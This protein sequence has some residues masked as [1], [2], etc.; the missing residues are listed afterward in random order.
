MVNTYACFEN[1]TSVHGLAQQF[2]DSSASP[3]VR[4]AK[5]GEVYPQNILKLALIID[6]LSN[7]FCQLPDLI[8]HYEEMIVGYF[9]I[10]RRE[11]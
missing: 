7:V 11:E 5:E 4:F 10:L 1:S 8:D 9:Y 6:H 2:S 3:F